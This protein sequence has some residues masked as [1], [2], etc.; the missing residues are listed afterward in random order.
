M[1]VRMMRGVGFVVLQHHVE[2]TPLRQRPFP[3]WPGP[4]SAAALSRRNRAATC[5]H[6]LRPALPRAGAVTRGKA[7]SAWLRSMSSTPC[8]A[9]ILRSMSSVR[10]SAPRHKHLFQLLGTYQNYHGMCYSCARKRG[11]ARCGLSVSC[12]PSSPLALMSANAQAPGLVLPRSRPP[13]LSR[14]LPLF[15]NQVSPAL[16]SRRRER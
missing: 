3:F 10:R 7:L 5:A 6:L 11:S 14:P 15:P 1:I 2:P 12:L 13:Y 4:S 9:S 16:P 8:C